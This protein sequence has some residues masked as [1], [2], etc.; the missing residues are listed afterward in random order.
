MDCV[1]RTAGKNDL[2]GLFSAADALIRLKGSQ[3][4]KVHK[5]YPP[6]I[7]ISVGK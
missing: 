3:N 2:K 1:I 7:I 4:L 6:N 5:P